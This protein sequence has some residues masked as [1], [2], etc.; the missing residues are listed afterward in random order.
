MIKLMSYIRGSTMKITNKDKLA[1][2]P[3]RC[4]DCNTLFIF[5][6]YNTYYREVGKQ[7]FRNNRCKRCIEE[8][9]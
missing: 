2:L 9:K 4:S 8:K 3:K 1:I 7:S 6:M 5:E